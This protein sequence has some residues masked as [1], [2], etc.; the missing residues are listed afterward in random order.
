MKIMKTAYTKLS[1][2]SF[3]LLIL[4]ACKKAEPLAALEPQKFVKLEVKGLV[5]SDTLEF[6]L[7]GQIVGTA[8]DGNF[9]FQDR[10][11][12]AGKKLQVRKKSDGKSVGEIL[13]ADGPYKQ[14]KK[15]FYDGV[16]FTDKIELTPVS[17]PSSMGIRLRFATT[18][19]D[20]YGG[21]VDVEF[22]VMARTTTRPR[23]TTYTSVKLVNNVTG[24]F[25]DFIE[26]PPLTEEA[27]LTKSYQLKVYKA[28]TTDLPYSSTNNLMITD[29]Q[30]NYGD[31]G[32][33]FMAGSSK[34][35]S[36]SPSI[37]DLIYIGDGYQIQDLADAFQ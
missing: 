14:V 3:C 19:P 26:L 12:T 8:I 18:F 21:P 13:I 24:S 31:I 35:I 25:G 9:T 1:L 2:L 11:Y 36:I 37:Q 23:V 15:V 20:F 10:V 22:F 5:L 32:A 4:F 29:P 27:G 17:D 34:L 28:G 16:T 33:L 30:N 6:V 7:D